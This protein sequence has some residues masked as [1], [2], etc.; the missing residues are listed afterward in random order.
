AAFLRDKRLTHLEPWLDP[1]NS[2]AFHFGG[3]TLPTSVL[4]DSA[5]REVW[6]FTGD[7][8]WSAPAAQTLLAEAK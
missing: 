7:N 5:G 4:Y 1:D 8:D 3:G 2:L 6:R